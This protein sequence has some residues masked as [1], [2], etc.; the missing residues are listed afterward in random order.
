MGESSI[1]KNYIQLIYNKT[2]KIIPDN[3]SKLILVDGYDSLLKNDISPIIGGYRPDLYYEFD[4]LM[5]IGEAKTQEDFSKKHSINQ[6]NEYLKNCAN[7]NGTSYLLLCCPWQCTVSLKSI[8]KKL[9]SNYSDKINII[10]IDE[11][12]GD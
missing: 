1:H 4:S 6:Y 5:I 3:H 10:F 11:I 2:L 7:Y 12:S 9:K 8:I